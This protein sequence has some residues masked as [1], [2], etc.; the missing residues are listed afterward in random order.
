MRDAQIIEPKSREAGREARLF[1][2]G[3]ARSAAVRKGLLLR[4]ALSLHEYD[5]LAQV[6][7]SMCEMLF[8]I[9][10]LRMGLPL[11]GLLAQMV[12]HLTFNQVVGGSS[13][14]CL[15]HKTL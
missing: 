9:A 13:P 5:V 3:K 7:F 10:A 6:V 1:S 14:P 12:E 15:T 4:Q 8:K 11:C 2:T